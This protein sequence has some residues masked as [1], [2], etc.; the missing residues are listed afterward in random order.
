MSS[1]LIRCLALMACFVAAAGASRAGATVALRDISW[2]SRPSS[3]RCIVTT[4]TPIQIDHRDFLAERGLFY[5][6]LYNVHGKISKTYEKHEGPFLTAHRF[7]GYAAEHVLRIIFYPTPGTKY[8]V[9]LAQSPP[10]VIIELYR[11]GESPTPVAPP[12]PKPVPAAKSPTPTPTPPPGAP[13]TPSD[14]PAPIPET[15]LLLT[16]PPAAPATPPPLTP[17]PAP[18]TSGPGRR[19]VIIDPGH[20]GQN[21]GAKGRTDGRTII[22]NGVNLQVAKRLA[23]MIQKAGNMDYYLT[24][25]DETFISL[26]DRVRFAEQIA[27]PGNG[28]CMFVSIHSNW[29][30]SSSARGVEFY[31][32]SETSSEA[33]RELEALENDEEYKDQLKGKENSI[34]WNIFKQM[35]EDKLKQR[36][37]EGF[38]VCRYLD[39]A[40]RQNG[41][42]ARHDRGVKKANFVVLKNF[43][44]PAVLVEIGFLS[45][46]T[47]CAALVTEDYQYNVAA[48]LFNGINYFFKFSD[49]TFQDLYFPLRTLSMD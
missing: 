18:R 17:P 44:M 29:S 48:A 19:K 41:Y 6:D 39:L 47:E 5:V 4:E 20:G 10:R 2:E 43:L 16:P 31:Y 15:A 42:F 37:E 9:R 24:R 25:T 12:S 38:L 49:Q 22:E 34:L 30:P 14:S 32:L 40:F 13:P 23:G 46:R 26:Y 28:P 27:E 45:N 8:R 11:P 7:V 1:R 36:R 21:Q 35:E 33:T 3:L